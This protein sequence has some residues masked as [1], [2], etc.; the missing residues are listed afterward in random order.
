MLIELGEL[1]DANAW[2]DKALETFPNEPELLAAKSVVLARNGDTKGALVF[3]D[4]SI[5]EQGDLPYVWLARGDVLLALKESN[6]DYC[7]EKALL[8]APGDW[9]VLWLGARI[10]FYHEQFAGALQLA[11]RAIG[12]DAGRA[13][14]WIEQGQCQESLG[15]M[16][17]AQ[18]SFSRALELDRDCEA[19]TNALVRLRSHGMAERALGWWRRLKQ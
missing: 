7:V 18:D 16:E 10:R 19:A 12:C 1:R 8:L 13:V 17:A 2:A 5:E 3:S 6:A 4:A 14:L 15:L 11:Q 9:G